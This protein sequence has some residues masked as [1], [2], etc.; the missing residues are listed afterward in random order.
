MQ[1]L[2]PVGRNAGALKYDLLSALMAYGL[3]QDKTVQRRV[4]RLMALITARY[5]W[6]RNELSTGQVEIA[7]L[8]CVDQRTVKREFAQLRNMGWLVL[9]TQGARG[10]VSVYQLDLGLI[11]GH[12][13][14]FWSNVGPDFEDRMTGQNSPQIPQ[15]STSSNVVSIAQASQQTIEGE[16]AWPT[17]MRR[18][19]SADPNR[20]QAWYAR[21]QDGGRVGGTVTILAPSAFVADY[22][23]QHL[24]EDVLLAFRLEDPSIS[25]LKVEIAR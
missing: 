2:K 4:M 25:M 9:K 3:A 23:R 10:R 21:L 20:F 7:R 8:W 6:Q 12:T 5:N 15:Q 22:L 11:V 1:V 14:P 16:G 18:L 17:A 24:V 13:Q 19:A